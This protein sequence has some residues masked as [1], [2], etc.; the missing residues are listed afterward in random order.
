MAPCLE[1][2]VL[3]LFPEMFTGVLNESILK[4]AIADGQLSVRLVNFRDFA[5][6]KHKTVDDY[7]FGGGAGMLLKP[8]P[9]F[10]AIRHI[11]SESSGPAG[12]VVLMTPQGK[13]FTQKLAQDFAQESRLV[14][15][16][17]HY[18]G[19]DERVRQELVTDE[20][21]IGDFVLT[22]GEIPAMA[23]ID[24][25]A[26]LLPGVLGNEESAEDDS[27]TSGLL[28]YPQYTRP[29]V[30]EGLAV[31]DVLLSGNHKRIAEWRHVHAL[32]RT[33]VRRPDLLRTYAMSE[34]DKEYISRWER[35]DF[36]D[37]DVFDR[38]H[39]LKRVSDPI[40]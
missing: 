19:F 33:W 5:N 30:Y 8:A 18:E 7:P 40:D 31:P 27:Y 11:Q 10:E 12:R 21:S 24:A 37:I 35:G 32:Y 9:L 1:I 20:V 28:E 39:E 4:R 13:P 14:L 6:D 29:A 22:G 15:V 17:G 34:K 2:I 38:Y 16:C 25:V 36:K 3:T 23:V 26:R